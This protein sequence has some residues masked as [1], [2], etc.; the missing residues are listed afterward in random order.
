M[1]KAMKQ[2]KKKQRGRR[3]RAKV[4]GT[5]ERPRL[6]ARRTNV[7]MYVQLV[8]DTRGATLAAADWREADQKKFPKNDIARAAEVGRR[9]A[10][11]AKRAGVE[12]VVFDRGGS[13]YHGKIRALAD[14]AR[15][16]GLKI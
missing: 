13:R 1:V 16:G 12:T 3:V 8:D 5:A 14:G 4:F 15:E 7:G 9:I 6:A 10:E 11:K 2:L